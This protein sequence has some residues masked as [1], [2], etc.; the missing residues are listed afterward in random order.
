VTH[1][2]DL[3]TWGTPD[4][5]VAGLGTHNAAVRAVAAEHPEVFFV[6]QEALMPRRREYWNDICHLT[7]RGAIEF[8]AN[9]GELLESR[10]LLRGTPHAAVR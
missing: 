2:T 1:R 8:A 3:A 9:I 5:I 7:A 4:A 10:G 6:D